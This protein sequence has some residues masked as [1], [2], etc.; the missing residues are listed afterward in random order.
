MPRPRTEAD[1]GEEELEECER[2]G[3]GAGSRSKAS[4]N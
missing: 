4:D 2:H 3:G 1:G